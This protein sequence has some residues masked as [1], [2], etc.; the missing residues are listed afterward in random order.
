MELRL[1]SAHRGGNGA[2]ARA[3]TTAALSFQRMRESREFLEVGHAGGVWLEGLV[4][5]S[6]S[7]RTDRRRRCLSGVGRGRRSER[8]ATPARCQGL[9]RGGGRSSQSIA[10]CR[11]ARYVGEFQIVVEHC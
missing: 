7:L 5:H 10:T 2:L 8:Q 6:E 9:R 4:L 1:E 3:D 11:V